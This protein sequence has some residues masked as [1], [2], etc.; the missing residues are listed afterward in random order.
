MIVP[1]QQFGDN[2]YEDAKKTIINGGTLTT[3]RQLH[4]MFWTKLRSVIAEKYPKMFE[5]DAEKRKQWRT[6][7]M[8]K[9]RL[10]LPK[11]A[12]VGTVA[13]SPLVEVVS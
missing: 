6:T 10:D 8:R 12:V 5:N 3:N 11:E 4:D 9:K 7:Y 1:I 13:V 2:W